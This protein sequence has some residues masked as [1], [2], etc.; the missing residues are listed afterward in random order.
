MLVVH[1]RYDDQCILSDSALLVVEL[2]LPAGVEKFQFPQNQ[3][4]GK[5]DKRKRLCTVSRPT[6]TKV[7]QLTHQPSERYRIQVHYKCPSERY[8]SSTSLRTKAEDF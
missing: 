5:F 2:R 3:R 4:D 6:I 1:G 7:P 8:A